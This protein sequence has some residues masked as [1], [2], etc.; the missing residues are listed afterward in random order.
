MAKIHNMRKSKES[1]RTFTSLSKYLKDGNNGKP[2][3]KRVSKCP[4]N[5][6]SFII[7]APTYNTSN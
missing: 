3:D 5:T 1:G 7:K 4:R 2:N 6:S